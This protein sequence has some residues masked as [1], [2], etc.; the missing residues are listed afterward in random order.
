MKYCCNR[1]NKYRDDEG[2]SEWGLV[3]SYD[4]DNNNRVGCA[5]RN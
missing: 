4:V 1:K 3:G 2:G 5:S